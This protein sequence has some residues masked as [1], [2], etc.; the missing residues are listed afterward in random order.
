MNKKNADIKLE[1]DEKVYPDAI[2]NMECEIQRKIISILE[3]ILKMEN[4]KPD[5]NFNETDVDSI[6]FIKLIVT[7]EDEFDI[8]FEDKYLSKEALPTIDALVECVKIK[9]K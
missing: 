8:E 9:I 3:N 4:L 6:A 7:V 5:F 1:N 2:G